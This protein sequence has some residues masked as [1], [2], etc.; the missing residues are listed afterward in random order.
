MKHEIFELSHQDMSAI[1]IF[2]RVVLLGCVLAVL[3]ADLFYW[4]P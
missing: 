1:D 4:R 3:L 2:W